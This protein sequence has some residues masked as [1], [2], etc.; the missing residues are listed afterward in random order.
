MGNVTTIPEHMF[1]V[2]RDFASQTGLC[3]LC[4]DSYATGLLGYNAWRQPLNTYHGLQNPKE[5]LG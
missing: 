1:H 2:N 5:T 3:I 4:A